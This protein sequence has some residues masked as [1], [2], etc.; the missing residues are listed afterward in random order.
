MIIE[1]VLCIPV[2]GKDEILAV[3]N[4]RRFKIFSN[5]NRPITG[6]LRRAEGWRLLDP[7]LSTFAIAQGA[8]IR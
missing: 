1:F 7:G 4:D 2:A 6:M 5:P 3:P 8:R